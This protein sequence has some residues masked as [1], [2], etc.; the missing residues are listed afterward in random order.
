[1][2]KKQVALSVYN[3][4]LS[5]DAAAQLRTQMSEEIRSK[6]V[7]LLI[8]SVRCE[9]AAVERRIEQ[10]PWAKAREDALKHLHEGSLMKRSL[11]GFPTTRQEK[12][13][14]HEQ[15]EIAN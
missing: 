9:Y 7:D 15:E 3:Q 11:E 4:N 1:L 8:S 2:L 10:I 6:P 5:Q 13:C 12:G 14:K